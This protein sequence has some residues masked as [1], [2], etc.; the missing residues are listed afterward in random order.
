MEYIEEVDKDKRNR[1]LS[2][3]EHTQLDEVEKNIRKIN[4]KFVFVLL[5]LFFFE[6]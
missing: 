2:P 6:R 4:R 5:L 3:D 1:E